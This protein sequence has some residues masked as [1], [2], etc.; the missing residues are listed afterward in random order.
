M[1]NNR[2]LFQA[3][4]GLSSLQVVVKI[5]VIYNTTWERVQLC[6]TNVHDID[7]I[8]IELMYIHMQVC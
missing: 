4:A 3:A 5:H 1:V 7:L 2:S 8:Y 6:V